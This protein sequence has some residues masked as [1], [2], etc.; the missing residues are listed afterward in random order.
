ME[1]LIKFD[2]SQ[3][4]YSIC[5]PTSTDPFP[6]VPKATGR[7]ESATLSDEP[8]DNIEGIRLISGIEYKFADLNKRKQISKVNL[9]VP[10]V[11]FNDPTLPIAVKRM[12]PL[13]SISRIFSIN[14]R[15]DFH[16]GRSEN[17]TIGT[18]ED[19]YLINTMGGAHPIHVHL[20]NFQVIKILSL[21]KT[22]NECTLYELDFIV[23]AMKTGSDFLNNLKYF[24]DPNDLRNI[25]YTAIC[26]DKSSVIY[27]S[28]D[29]MERLNLVNT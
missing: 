19:W 4:N 8:N 22:S 18:Y 15:T 25:N 12:R 16:H 29:L 5:A 3:K 26:A 6:P 11:D 21:R 13:M 10:F 17:P 20:I 23:E 14:G 27:A 1:L 2:P 24:P 28:A 9:S 7:T